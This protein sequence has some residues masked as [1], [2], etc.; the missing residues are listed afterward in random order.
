MLTRNQNSEP[1]PIVD[2]DSTTISY[3]KKWIRTV[4]PISFINQHLYDYIEETG[5]VIENDRIHDILNNDDSL[6][7]ELKL[8]NKVLNKLHFTNNDDMS[9]TLSSSMKFDD[10]W[11]KS[12]EKI[13]VK[14]LL[15]EIRSSYKE[16]EQDT[17]EDIEEEKLF[18][19]LTF[20]SL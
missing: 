17:D 9:F 10:W 2:N 1:F 4:L 19:Q 14:N 16:K 6:L 11:N 7:K 8:K 15:K 13:E 20:G 3:L 18:N 5:I 12:D